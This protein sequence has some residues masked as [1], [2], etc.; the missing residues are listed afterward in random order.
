MTDS[1]RLFWL[2]VG[3]VL[4]AGLVGLYL[5]TGRSVQAATS[6]RYED[7]ILCSGAVA[8]TPRA[9]TDGVWLLDY[10][11]GRLLGTVIDR[12]LGKI[13]GWAEVDLVNEFG[14]PARQNAHFMMVTGQISQSQ[15][16]LYVAETTTGKFGVYTMGPRPDGQSGVVINRHDMGS[17]HATPAP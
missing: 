16:A 9:L 7:Y 17:F 6:D 4:G 2:V 1:G 8:I 5:G 14:I 11:G 13:V 12:N 10:R 15:A 3:L